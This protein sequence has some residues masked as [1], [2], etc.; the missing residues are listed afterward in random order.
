M[1]LSTIQRDEQARW[2]VRQRG[3]NGEKW[4]LFCLDPKS[5]AVPASQSLQAEIALAG[6]FA[7]Q[8]AEATGG[9]CQHDE[10]K[11]RT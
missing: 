10:K 8:E 1:G 3:R 5:T 2:Y 6:R 7:A 4:D 9:C 11:K